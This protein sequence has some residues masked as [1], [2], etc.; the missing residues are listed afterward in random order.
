MKNVK[1][2]AMNLGRSIKYSAIDNIKKQAPAMTEMATMNAELYKEIHY[3]L[4]NR[5][6]LIMR[7]D[8]LIRK[9]KVYE[10][11]NETRKS[12]FEDLKTGNFYNKSRIESITKR[13]MGMENGFGDINEPGEGMD[14]DFSMDDEDYGVDLSEGDIVTVEAIES[15]SKSSAAMISTA[16]AR[17]SDYIVES[18]RAIHKMNYIQNT[19]LFNGLNKSIGSLNENLINSTKAIADTLTTHAQN[20]KTFFEETTKYSKENNA[21]LKELVEMERNR[22]KQEQEKDRNSTNYDDISGSEGGI[23]FKAYL[24]QVGKN[25]SN[26]SSGIS[27]LNSVFGED[28]NTLLTIA[29]SPLKFITDFLT[30]KM[31]GSTIKNSIK[32]FDKSISGA[33][34][35]LLSR[36]NLM[37]RSENGIVRN[38]GEILGIDNR[39]KKDIDTSKYHKGV[40]QWD[41]KSKRALEYVLPTY[42]SK[43]LAAVSG[44]EESIYDY[45]SGKFKTRRS[46]ISEYKNKRKSA[47][48]SAT[49]DTKNNFENMMSTIRFSRAEDEKSFKDDMNN[50]FKFF[51]NNGIMFD[52]IGKDF[53]FYKQQGLNIDSQN[54]N[55]FKALFRSMSKSDQM[56]F[57]AD[58]QS[59]RNSFDSDMRRL[60]KDGS[61]LSILF[62]ES[63]K[64]KTNEYDKDGKLKKQY[65]M[66]GMLTNNIDERGK[67]IFWYLRNTYELLATGIKVYNLNGSGGNNNSGRRNRRSRQNSPDIQAILNRDVSVRDERVSTTTTNNEQRALERRNRNEIRNNPDAVFI[68]TLTEGEDREVDVAIEEHIRLV[69][70]QRQLRVDAAPRRETFVDKLLRAGNLSDKISLLVEKIKNATNKPQEMI[71][72][73]IN[74]ADIR[75]YEVLYGKEKKFHRGEEIYGII[76][77]LVV[78]IKHTFNNL[79]Q[80]LDEKILSPL[81]EKIDRRGGFK[82]MFNSALESMGI[83]PENNIFTRAKDYFFG[84]DSIF[85]DIKQNLKEDFKAITGFVKDSL[86]DV[87]N[88]LDQKFNIRGR[89]RSLRDRLGLNNSSEDTD[90]QDNSDDTTDNDTTVTV[91]TS[92]QSRLHQSINAAGKKVSNLGRTR[93]KIMTPEALQAAKDM[94]LNMDWHDTGAKYINKTKVALIHKGEAVLTPEER[95]EWERMKTIQDNKRQLKET[96]TSFT[97]EYGYRRKVVSAKLKDD[98]YTDEESLVSRMSREVKDI[99]SRVKKSLLGTDDFGEFDDKFNKAKED[100]SKNFKEYFPKIASGGILGGASALL[101]GTNPLLG[102]FVGATTS[103]IKRSESLQNYLFGEKDEDGRYKGG[104]LLGKKAMNVIQTYVPDMAKYGIAGAVTG[105][106]PFVP[107]GPITGLMLGAGVGF[108]KHNREFSQALFG[109]ELKI[110]KAMESVKE[111]LPKIGIGAI[112]GTIFGPFGL[113]GNLM[114]G[115]AVGW[116]SDTDKFKEAM[117]GTYDENTKQ[118][119]G[120]LLPAIRNTV[121]KPMTTWAK[122][123]KDNVL[124][125]LSE[126]VRKPLKMA[127]K[128]F[129]REF[130]YIGKNIV[131]RVGKGLDFVFEKFFGAPTKEFLEE[132]IF[133]PMASFFGKLG[134]GAIGLG[135]FMLT[136]PIRMLTMG[137]DHLANKQLKR[138]GIEG[139]D[140]E[141]LL[142]RYQK[143]PKKFAKML[144]K[145]K[146]FNR[147]SP[148]ELNNFMSGLDQQLAAQGQSVTTERQEVENEYNRPNSVEIDSN[149]QLREIN[150]NLRTMNNNI[151][152][153]RDNQES[154][155]N[156]F[157]ATEVG[158]V[159]YDTDSNGETRPINDAV[160][161]KYLAKKEEQDAKQQ[162]LFDFLLGKQKPKEER[163][164]IKEQKGLFETLKDIVGNILKF[165]LPAL[166]IAAL[167]AGLLPNNSRT[168]ADGSQI[169]NTDIIEAGVRG[170]QKKLSSLL[171]GARRAGGKIFDFFNKGGKESAEKT[172]KETGEKVVKESADRVARE[173][174]EKALKET[175]E[176]AVKESAD[177]VARE[178]AEK[179]I[180]ETGEKIVKESVDTGKVMN[181]TS[182]MIDDFIQIANKTM[183]KVMDDIVGFCGKF[184]LK[185]KPQHMDNIMKF[186]S[187]L[188]KPSI[189][190]KFTGKI[191]TGLLKMGVSAASFLLSDVVAA[192]W[193]GLTGGTK[194]ETAN[195]FQIPV[196]YVTFPM[197]VI[198]GSMKALLNISYLFVIDIL[199]EIS[200]I[201]TGQD[202]IHAF[203][204]TIYNTIESDESTLKM[205]SGQQQLKTDYE[206]YKLDNNLEDLSF[207]AY[208]DKTNKSV[209][210]KGVDYYNDNLKGKGFIG[211]AKQLIS[212][213]MKNSGNITDILLSLTIPGYGQGKQIATFVGDS[214]KKLDMEK[215]GMSLKNETIKLLTKNPI[216]AIPN[217]VKYANTTGR[218]LN[219]YDRLQGML[220][221]AIEDATFGLV[222][223]DKTMSG[224]GKTDEMLKNIGSSLSSGVK[225]LMENNP[226][227]V[228]GH[229]WRAISAIANGAPIGDSLLEL[230]ASSTEA[231]TFGAIKR[232]KTMEGMQKTGDVLGKLASNLWDGI[233]HFTTYNPINVIPRAFSGYI[234][235]EGSFGDKMLGSLAYSIEALTFGAVKNEDVVNSLTDSESTV[236]KLAS[237]AWE[238][239]VNFVTYNPMNI[240]PRTF[241]GYIDTEGSFTDKMLGSLAYGI[242]ALTFGAVKNEDIKHIFT[243]GEP[244]AIASDLLKNTNEFILKNPLG[245]PISFGKTWMETEGSFG[246]KFTASLGSAFESLTFGIINK[247]DVTSFFNSISLGGIGSTV[248]DGIK[249]IFGFGPSHTTTTNT[250]TGNTVGANIPANQAAY[251]KSPIYGMGGGE[252]GTSNIKHYSQKDPKWE[253]VK[254]NNGK[255]TIKQTLGNSGCAPMSAAIVQSAYM[256][257]V[258]INPLNIAKY[259]ID[260]GHKNID[261]GVKPSFFNDYLPS[262][263]IVTQN[264]SKHE[265]IIN[266]LKNNKPVILMGKSKGGNTPFGDRPHYVVATGIDNN[267]NVIVNDPDSKTGGQTFNIKDTLKATTNAIRT[268]YKNSGIIQT[269]PQNQPVGN[270]KM[271]I[272]NTYKLMQEVIKLGNDMLKDIFGIPRNEE[273]FDMNTGLPMQ[274]SG[275]VDMSLVSK[276]QVISRINEIFKNSSKLKNTGSIYYNCYVKYK[277]DPFLVAAITMQETGGSSSILNTKNNPGGLMDPNKNWEEAQSFSSISNGIDAMFK[278][279]ASYGKKYGAYTIEEIGAIYCPIGAK[280]DPKNLNQ[281]WVS[282]VNKFYGQLTQ[283]LNIN[284]NNIGTVTNASS[285]NDF[286]SK[287]GMKVTSNYGNRKNP[288][289]SGTEFHKG[290]DYTHSLGY[291]ITSPVRG[292]VVD[293]YKN[294]N[295][296]TGFGHALRVM[297]EKGLVHTFAHLKD[298]PSLKNGAR[299]NVG[300]HVGKMGSTGASTGPHLH[301]QINQNKEFTSQTV[302]PNQ[303]FAQTGIKANLAGNMSGGY[304]KEG[305]TTSKSDNKDVYSGQGGAKDIGSEQIPTKQKTTNNDNLIKIIIELLIKVVDN[306]DNL[307]AIVTLLSQGLKVEIPEKLLKSLKGNKQGMQTIIKDSV[308]NNG[309][310]GNEALIKSLER[311]AAE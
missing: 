72:N 243:G 90:S 62:D 293:V 206:Q 183:G 171:K 268:S 66:A 223:F 48:D 81:K 141:E 255:D 150:E 133:K 39:M 76:D 282:G 127:F 157:L 21:L 248:W 131:E 11:V 170:L 13:S 197:R 18:N 172:I 99:L 193:G 169:A 55:I 2:Y 77:M 227:N 239:I 264:T 107:G 152:G 83:D 14:F 247:N 37:A 114:V 187:K 161:R 120:G 250:N 145:S 17:S 117:Y 266:S 26:K 121:V 221:V 1:Q 198:G 29:G 305:F 65:G 60:E 16:V 146:M 308:N 256:P 105:L 241:K 158:V 38:I 271:S 205:E 104:A 113:M 234:E 297:D 116:M 63:N 167:L 261:G 98:D 19:E 236:R 165:A 84:P 186:I 7:T 126:E 294:M 46:I 278:N 118:M 68:E 25:I 173:T 288:L 58:I 45:E 216:T 156:T 189:L 159:Q 225:Y 96:G 280:N 9:S 177:S 260:K 22:Y 310:T 82:G 269:K 70:E 307:S 202:F 106:I 79:N 85:T 160:H 59:G 244:K 263:G 125:F 110:E 296:K 208:N 137:G 235:T 138:D 302:D 33:F 190:L 270:G 112:A 23:D 47:V 217:A 142:Y 149:N 258:D 43:I 15:S 262:K 238:G 191:S 109:D 42:L 231:F 209:V 27:S 304:G 80:W 196:D 272:A 251:G 24:K 154:P 31:I 195:L 54:Y 211:G 228:V 300:D 290:I 64:M 40:T 73:A 242:E 240:I 311:L 4:I 32:N 78:D 298:K 283:G 91:E 168:D 129:I 179:A 67:N 100:I 155:S 103:L 134:K 181:S 295:E 162:A 265:D 151:N 292:E 56:K 130:K 89:G 252:Y 192:A 178:T 119:E 36:F 274:S 44:Q 273:T 289:G 148:A 279:L 5:R 259:A 204:V 101:F 35:T 185:I 30:D 135:K 276:E 139:F 306:T 93:R 10:A 176:K 52:H 132:K 123:I 144:K 153:I 286:Y 166:S 3:A 140:S 284:Y 128:P 108:L 94:V 50:F 303:Y 212:D 8:K 61:L 301:Y 207:D 174:A 226:F 28:S 281:Y 237:S 71:A 232:E 224:L 188:L 214:I 285:L 182:K 201:L 213:G 122:G 245:A 124:H 51:F 95:I 57:N 86:K 92:S 164:D 111:K 6:Q 136:S 163:D 53:D 291:P 309:N 222:P 143:N 180:K 229:G 277:F 199:N 12:I 267:G 210:G 218:D 200:I 219:L 184:S 75:L 69:N 20:S 230:F 147:M 34:A 74:M 215:V 299:I 115:S 253:S 233:V 249:S 41:G 257:G 275:L 254:F 102:A 175:G 220:A 87:Y 203:A 287:Q 194:S 246:D 88:E 49:S 97:R